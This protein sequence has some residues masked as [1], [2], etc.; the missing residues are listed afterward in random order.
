MDST[1]TNSDQKR[2]DFEHDFE[3]FE[4]NRMYPPN[5]TGEIMIKLNDSHLMALGR[6]VHFIKSGICQSMTPRMQD[7]VAKDIRLI[8]E[9]H[10]YVRQQIVEPGLPMVPESIGQG[11]NGEKDGSV[12]KSS[13]G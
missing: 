11:N 2:H 1:M 8:E 4:K 7:N 13:S 5:H 9:V 6:S 3:V 12:N 10:K